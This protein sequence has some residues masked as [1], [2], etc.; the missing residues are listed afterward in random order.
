MFD[1]LAALPFYFANLQLLNLFSIL[2]ITR[3]QS[4]R[5][6]VTTLNLSL[7]VYDLLGILVSLFLVYHTMAFLWQMAAPY[8][9]IPP[10]FYISPPL[11]YLAYGNAHLYFKNYYYALVSGMGDGE[12]GPISDWQYIT[13]CLIM[14]FG[15]I[16]NAKTFASLSLVIAE[17]N[18]VESSLGAKMNTINTIMIEF[19]IPYSTKKTVRHFL[20]SNEYNLWRF[21]SILRFI[22]VLSPSLRFR[23]F[24]FLFARAVLKNIG[25]EKAVSRANSKI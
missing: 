24:N 2:K 3:A 4:I 16:Y 18:K 10:L 21:N 11:A 7:V 12:I 8:N 20:R 13:V 19:D 23:V 1:L 15:S 25:F 9:W 22:N 5:R 6:M 14:F 17:M